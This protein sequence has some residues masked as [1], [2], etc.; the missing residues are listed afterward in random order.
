MRTRFFFT[1]V[2]ISASILTL[3]IIY[4]AGGL[5]GTG[6]YLAAI[7]AIF[8]FFFL[9]QRSRARLARNLAKFA[10]AI[11]ARFDDSGGLF[12][13]EGQY[14]SIP[15]GFKEAN[16][17]GRSGFEVYC[18]PTKVS[19]D[20]EGQFVCPSEN[21]VLAQGRVCLS[22]ASGVFSKKELSD[23]D[24]LAILEELRKAARVA[25]TGTMPYK[26]SRGWKAIF[27]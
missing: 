10:R 6:L 22:A 17:R 16:F 13:G 9:T 21:T 23:N 3:Y 15:V 18:R 12:N 4:R 27:G 11:N 1:A 19:G 2:I 26:R 24:I 8:I 20:F 7:S 5:P 25:E 14:C